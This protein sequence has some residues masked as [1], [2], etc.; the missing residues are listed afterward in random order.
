MWSKEI[1]DEISKVRRSDSMIRDPYFCSSDVWKT[2]K[3]WNAAGYG[4]KPKAVGIKAYVNGQM[5]G[6]C[7]RYHRLEVFKR[8]ERK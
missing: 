3:Q 4:L 5:D 7:V 8:K 6:R 1:R 2:E